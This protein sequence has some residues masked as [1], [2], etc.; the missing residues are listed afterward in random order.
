M[1]LTKKVIGL[2]EITLILLSGIAFAYIMSE[3]NS[4]IEY[5]PVESKESKFILLIREKVLNYLSYGLVSAQTSVKT[6]LVDNSGSY[7]QEYPSETCDSQ[8]TSSCFPGRRTEFSSCQL[9]TC[10]D[11]S[12]GLCNAGTPRASC[13]D[14]GGVWSAQTPVQCNRGCCLIGPDGNG[15]A[16]QARFATSQECTN[17]RQ[18]SGAPTEWDPQ[19][20]SEIQCLSRVRT[21]REGACVLEFLPELDKYNCQFTTEVSCLTNGGDFYVGQLCTNPDLNTKCEM[22]QNTQCFDGKDGIYFVDSCGN[23]A[24][25][26]DSSKLNNLAYWSSIVPIE[27]ICSLSSGSDSLANQQRCGN[28]DYLAGNTCGSP[29]SGLDETSIYGQYVCKDLA[30]I[31]NGVRKEHGESWC[32]F[33]S[34][35]GLDGQNASNEERAVDV[36]GSR[37]YKKFCSE[38]EV[39]LEPC[40]E[41]RNGVCVEQDVTD[42]F[43]NAQCR[44]NT[45]SLCTSYNENA[46]KLAKC[47][48]SPDCYLK[49]VEID[50]W[51]FDVCVPKYPPGLELA[52]EPQPDSESICK[53]ATQ[54]CTYYEKKNIEGRWTCKI[55]CECKEAKFAETMNNLCMSLGDCGSHVN[56]AGELGK[57]YSTSGDRSPKISDDYVE[58]LKKYITPKPGQRVSTFTE[59]QIEALFG[60][61]FNFEDPNAL[62]RQI[63]QLGLGA[64]GALAT[65]SSGSAILAPSWFHV[66]GW[67]GAANGALVGAG[68][69]YIIGLA[70]GLEGDELTTAVVI[71]AAAGLLYIGLV[72][73]VPT[74]AVAPVVGWIAAIIIVV[75]IVVL[76]VAGVGEYREKKVEF[77]CLPWQ[78]PSGGDNCAKCDSLGVECTAY[79]CASLGK[80]CE[81]INPETENEACVNINPNDATAP[82]I[83]FNQTSLAQGFTYEEFT[84]GVEIK[85]S[86]GDGCLQEYSVVTFGIVTNEPSQCK[87]SST[88]PSNYEEMDDTYFDSSANAYVSRHNEN[89]AMPTLDSLEVPGINPSRRGDYNL[90]V[91]CDDKSGNSNDNAYD[92]RFCVSP[93]DDLQ[94]PKISRFS[95]ES[96]GI[97]G[98]NSSSYN[99]QFYTD[100]P[101]TC[102]FSTTDQEYEL[103]E[104]EANCD[105]AISQS[106]L[107]GWLCS[108]TLPISQDTN[109]YYFRCADK[110]WLGVN[111]QQSSVTLIEGRNK[112][113]Q[114]IPYEVRRTTTPLTISSVTPDDRTILS[115]TE[116]VSVTLEVVTA[117]GIES[118]E[119]S[120]KYSFDGNSYIDFFT[121]SLSNHRQ[122]WDTL[123]AGSYD[124]RL[125][126]TDRAGNIVEGSAQFIIEVDNTGP[127]ITRV[128]NSGNSLNVITNEASICE[129]STSTC[130]FEFETGTALSG[131]SRVHTMPYSNGLTYKIKCRDTFGNVGSCL[132]VSGGY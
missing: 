125:R 27:R 113:T 4:L 130:S 71:G 88:R 103:M 98:L 86:S 22:T 42:S 114:S 102:K 70:L 62:A 81:L 34:W 38:G 33:D 105:N 67:T 51:K 9:G 95:P 23:K 122:T 117:G 21:Q 128:Y 12:L 75:A 76:S 120:C 82:D 96:P 115:A 19:I 111:I 6:C 123:F 91:L 54:T 37:H 116:P 83:S 32:A 13:E 92:I 126:C 48:E 121:T 47:E 99:L 30:C 3:T 24:N 77:K 78:P 124:I 89:T 26:Y 59:E 31:D 36:P 65:L 8:C 72:E 80:T 40:A 2:F 43:T 129:Y 112:N 108:A 79:K 15:G 44:T 52:D 35:I 16:S 94:P 41:Y 49:H 131:A 61:D 104:N 106:T 84:N 66:T 28:C 64:A 127:L 20:Q 50:K 14:E 39:R 74:L 93:E 109:N 29:Q 10:Y 11:S 45:G 17:L 56:L 5:L 73:L 60:T 107:R 46:D 18:S 25:I 101:A 90:Y 57:G 87:I 97:T 63:S 132:T 110:P 69:G 58:G 68:I 7:C 100:E 53:A 85:S 119:A 55:N 118:G 1:V